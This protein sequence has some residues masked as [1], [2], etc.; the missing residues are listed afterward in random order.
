MAWIGVM[1]DGTLVEDSEMGSMPVDGAL[2]AVMTLMGEGHRVTVCTSRFAP[3]PDSERH[4]MKE[5]I[6]QELTG[7][8]FPPLEVWSGTT[9]PAVDMMIGDNLITFDGEWGLA[10]AQCEQMLSDR[11][12]IPEAPMDDGT[13]PVDP[14]EG[15]SPEDDSNNEGEE[16]A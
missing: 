4:R 14:Q 3:M 13:M 5:Q 2:E 11:G 12:L 16:E 6:E 8:G 9:M 15:V 10:L 1:L 7:L